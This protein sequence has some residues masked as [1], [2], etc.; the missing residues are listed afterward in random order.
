MEKI[1]NF[2]IKIPAGFSKTVYNDKIN[3]PY[4]TEE[5][6][7]TA[8]R[9]IRFPR[10][11]VVGGSSSINGHLYVR[12]QADDYD[13]WAQK[14]CLGWSWSDVLP[15]FMK[16]ETRPEGNKN[17]RG[18]EGPLHIS[19]LTSPHPLAKLFIETAHSIGIKKNMDYNSG[20]QEGSF[21][22]QTMIK[23]SMRWSASDAYLKPILYQK[24]F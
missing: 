22:Y 11:K 5:T 23:N 19:D 12:G 10:G 13:G 18:N 16:A 6:E 9:K 2:Y 3:W 20:D 7:N 15:Y 8:N 4:Y 1:T 17:F 24:K 14:G 21:L